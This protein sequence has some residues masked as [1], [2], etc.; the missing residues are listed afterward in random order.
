MKQDSIL[1]EKCECGGKIDYFELHKKYL[2]EKNRLDTTTNKVGLTMAII[3]VI[4]F[5]ILMFYRIYSFGN[6][7]MMNSDGFILGMQ[8][9]AFLV[10][11]YILI[12]T[13]FIT[14][15]KANK[16]RRY[17][18]NKKRK[19][20][21]KFKRKEKYWHSLSNKQKNITISW[22]IMVFCIYM[23]PLYLFLFIILVPF[24]NMIG[25]MP[26]QDSAI[27]LLLI[28][29]AILITFQYI[30]MKSKHRGLDSLWKYMEKN[31]KNKHNVNTEI[32]FKSKKN[33]RRNV[34]E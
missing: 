25:N 31:L 30:H 20:F 11:I 26:D 18:S 14:R 28:M 1:N 22:V 8:F 12:Y 9:G 6:P 15:P 7:D 27:V 13:I 16:Y 17:D 19:S 29:L 10:L 32:L 21:I 5:G 24:I 34:N 2:G 23:T 4:T 3:V 33:D